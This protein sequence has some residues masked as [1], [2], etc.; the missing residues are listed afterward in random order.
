MVAVDLKSL[1]A[2]LNDPCRRSLEAA[3]GLTLSRSNFNVEIEHWLLKVLEASD[4]DLIAILRNYDVEPSRLAADLTRVLDR[5]KTGNTRAPALSPQVVTLMREAWTLASLDYG[6]A[7]IRSGHLLTALLSEETLAPIGREASAQLARIP[8]EALRREL[9]KL[10]A[11]TGE[12]GTPQ[13]AEAG[14][15]AGE[16]AAVTPGGR[17]PSLDQ[18]T[19]D[20]TGRAKA[21]KIDPVLGRDAEI[22]QVID[23]LTRRRQN[24]PILTGEAGVGKTAVVEGFAL[25]IASGDVPP[26]L[27]NVAVRTLD[28]GLLQAGAGVKGEF[29]NRLKSVIDEV[30][31]SP[32]P[33]I[34]FIDEAHTL[35]GAGG[36]AGQNDAANLLKP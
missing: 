17:T 9:P 10:T 30:K 26:A 6:S 18:F 3:A 14:A 22:R 25:R 11:N 24:N 5:L 2:K 16:G 12:A 23:I 34:L 20:L 7:R 32:T 1:V 36:A 21:G 35:I 28:L 13:A 19:I 15:P 4:S 27:Q 33:I 29:E 31:R 8:P